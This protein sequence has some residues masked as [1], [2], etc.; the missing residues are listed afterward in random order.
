MEERILC[1]N[2]LDEMQSIMESKTTRNL[3][4][5][6][7]S[8]GFIVIKHLNAN[9]VLVLTQDEKEHLIQYIVF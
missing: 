1:G 9:F 2:I 5:P 4:K 3:A 8:R 6:K 7:V